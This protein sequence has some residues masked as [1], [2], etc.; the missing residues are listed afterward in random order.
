MS[1]ALRSLAIHSASLEHS[2]R[3]RNS[4]SVVEAAVRGWVL[5]NSKGSVYKGPRRHK[6]KIEAKGALYNG[7]NSLAWHKRLASFI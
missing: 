4:D 3:A 5:L 2:E 7:S 6:N 1:K